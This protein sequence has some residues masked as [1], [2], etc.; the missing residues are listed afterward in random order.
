MYRKIEIALQGVQQALQ[1]SR[2]ISTAPLLEG[3]TKVGDESV[4]FCNIVDTVEVRLQHAQEEKAQATQA[5]KK[6]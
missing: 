2:A 4:Q 5:L 3:T 6:S 1:S